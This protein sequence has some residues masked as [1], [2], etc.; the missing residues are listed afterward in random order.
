MI[1]KTFNLVALSIASIN[2]MQQLNPQFQH[3]FNAAMGPAMNAANTAMP[4]ADRLGHTAMHLANSGM[5]HA[6]QAHSPFAAQ[7]Q[8]PRLR[9]AV[10][11]D[12]PM[13]DA[14]PSNV[15]E[16]FG[17]SN[18]LNQGVSPE[19]LANMQRL[20]HQLQ[21]QMNQLAANVET[22]HDVPRN[23]PCSRARTLSPRNTRSNNEPDQTPPDSNNNGNKK[24]GNG[25]LI[26]GLVA[27]TIIVI[28][29]GI[30]YFKRK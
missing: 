12:M 30:I 5:L 8:D 27:L 28:V 11:Q 2:A 21:D 23:N 16:G 15:A 18:P 24:G 14:G 3:G 26:A 6:D 4:H 9:S 13:R 29:S 7:L 10:R 19:Q 17:A 1:L 20:Q 22:N 25:W